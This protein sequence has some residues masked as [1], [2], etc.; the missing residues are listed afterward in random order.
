MEITVGRQHTRRIPGCCALLEPRLVLAHRAKRYGRRQ[1]RRRTDEHHFQG[2][3]RGEEVLDEV[4]V[5]VTDPNTTRYVDL[6]KSGGAQLTQRL[7]HRQVTDLVARRQLVDREA[8]SKRKD[9][10]NNG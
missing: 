8:C 4:L 6:E 9:T 5:D 7:A 3:A 10:G 1:L 2:T